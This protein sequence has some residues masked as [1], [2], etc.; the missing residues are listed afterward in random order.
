MQRLVRSIAIFFFLAGLASAQTVANPGSSS[1]GGS[2]NATIVGPLSTP[3]DALANPTGAVGVNNFPQGW[4]G[5]NWDRLRT[6]TIGNTVA[7]TGLQ[8]VVK[9][10]E[11]L[12]ALPTLTTGT[13]GASQCDAGGQQFVDL[14]YVLGALMAKTNPLYANIADGT[15]QLTAALS[16]WGTAP[17]G[18][19]VMGVNANLFSGANP[20]SQNQTTQ[21]HSLDINLVSVLGA[22]SAL[23][24]PLYVRPTDGTTSISVAA[25]ST[26]P[27]AAQ[28]ALVTAQTPNSANTCINPGSTMNYL[29]LNASTTSAVQIIALAAGKKITVC[30][31]WV[32]GGGTTPTFSLVY[33]T[34]TNCGTG[35]TTLVPAA[36]ILTTV[37][38]FYPSNFAQAASANAVCTLLTGTSP[39]A[40]GNISYTQQ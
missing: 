23:S 13:Y 2:S 35:Q 38:T 19:F 18:T 33:G 5:T 34:G 24:N 31:L 6:A 16:A 29:A 39:T 26:P 17:A 30:S 32:M 21:S 10:C 14:N 25:A 11:F 1:G 7:P 27:A 37:P 40:V 9:Y 15:N 28:P 8:A 20:I 22:T 36:A 4:N 12:T 3:A